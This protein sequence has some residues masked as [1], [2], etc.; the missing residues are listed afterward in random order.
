MGG[1]SCGTCGE[2][3]PRHFD[4]ALRAVQFAE[5]SD[6]VARFSP[7]GKVAARR[8]VAADAVR[9]E[10]WSRARDMPKFSF[11]AAGKGRIPCRAAS[12][13]A[14]MLRTGSR[15]A[16]ARPCS[17]FLLDPRRSYEFLK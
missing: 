14:A 13:F 8:A 4:S 3:L 1:P 12:T 2:L 7:S 11:C 9:F 10:I 5:T 16:N 15:G 17:L 6:D